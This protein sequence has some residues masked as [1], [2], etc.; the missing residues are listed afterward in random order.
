M[1]ITRTPLRISIAGGG[2][3]LP[4]YYEQHGGFVLS[5]AISKYIFITVNRTFTP[6]YFLKYSALERVDRPTDI[7]HPIVRE[8]LV[9]HDIG[10]AVEIVSMADIPAGT[11]LGS[12]GAF[13]VGLLRAVYAMQRNHIAAADLA[14]E[15]CAVEIEK[16][17]RPVGKQDQYVAAFGG[18]RCYEFR[19]DGSVVVSPLDISTATLHDLEEHLLMFFTGYSRGADTV[20]QEQKDRSEG[21][22][23]AMIDNL[24]F[25]KELG[26][27]S[28]A[29][30][31]AGATEEF[32]ALMHEHWQHKKK[33]SAA[34]SN[35]S[36][37]RWYDVGRGSGA[38]GGKLVG[39]GAGG[40]LLFYTR[41]P[42]A[43]RKVMA[44][45]GLVEVRF[46]F[47]HDGSTLLV[48]D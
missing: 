15:A 39:A 18:V 41:E 29:A 24:H 38:I 4:S 27:R 17:R 36:I 22:D 35:G 7:E 3:D 40:F 25:V 31:E 13:T 14:D 6:D 9:A 48:R 23:A 46:T 37:D 20:L 34:M 30:L 21:G 5:A 12:S 26:L 33:R 11:G 10:P 42:M 1:I 2:T 32:A 44:A 16:L 28:K 19:Q 8:V 43:L 47:D 45:E